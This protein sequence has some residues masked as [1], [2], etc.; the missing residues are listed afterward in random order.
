M[1]YPRYPLHSSQR[2]LPKAEKTLKASPAV[3]LLLHALFP[4]CLETLS[5]SLFQGVLNK[6]I[7]RGYKG[8]VTQHKRRG[9]LLS[10]QTRTLG[11]EKC[12]M[13]ELSS[14]LFH[15]VMLSVI[16]DEMLGHQSPSNAQLCIIPKYLLSWEYLKV[17]SWQQKQDSCIKLN[18][19]IKS[20]LQ[21]KGRVI[22][23]PVYKK[24]CSNLL[25]INFLLHL[26]SIREA[27]L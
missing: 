4:T 17:L 27:K 5:H 8:R 24:S 15:R 9:E 23:P 7:R 20:G 16:I 3:N 2:F 12:Q 21:G 18:P 11:D 13:Q 1:V 19:E 26:L 14:P 10:R 22:S 25:L 6:T